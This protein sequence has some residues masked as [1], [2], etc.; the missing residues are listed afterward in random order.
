MLHDRSNTKPPIL[1][2][3]TLARVMDSPKFQLRTWAEKPETHEQ[4][5]VGQKTS[6]SLKETKKFLKEI[7][8][9]I[10]SDA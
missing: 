9:S 8:K 10:G 7:E 1:T 4:L 2:S 3:E 5:A 6:R